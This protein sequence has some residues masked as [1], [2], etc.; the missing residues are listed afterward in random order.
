MRSG[1]ELET[2]QRATNSIIIIHWIRTSN[3]LSDTY[4]IGG[5]PGYHSKER[6]EA[7]LSAFYSRSTFPKA[8]PD[9]PNVVICGNEW[10]AGNEIRRILTGYSKTFGFSVFIVP[11]WGFKTAKLIDEPEPRRSTLQRAFAMSAPVAP[12][13]GK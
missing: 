1:I 12:P 5:I 8:G 7:F 4:Q 10:G 3:G 6:V 9:V 13:T 11:N 2:R